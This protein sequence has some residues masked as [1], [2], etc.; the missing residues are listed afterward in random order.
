MLVWNG[1]HKLVMSGFTEE[2]GAFCLY[3]FYSCLVLDVASAALVE[4]LVPYL[5]TSGISLFR[6][7]FACSQ[8]YNSR[9]LQLS[10]LVLRQ[11]A[12]NHR[13]NRSVLSLE[14]QCDSTYAYVPWPS[15]TQHL[16]SNSQSRYLHA[17]SCVTAH[18]PALTTSPQ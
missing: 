6:R 13:L 14:K 4:M 5:H 10:R 17:G 7:S 3:A 16:S 8:K 18:S 15:Q 12:S 2:E 11:S 9:L 1:V